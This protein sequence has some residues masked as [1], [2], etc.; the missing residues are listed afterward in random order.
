M[1]IA[2][3]NEIVISF[4]RNLDEERYIYIYTKNL[5]G[6]T[7]TSNLNKKALITS[8]IKYYMPLNVKRNKF[9]VFMF[10]FYFDEFYLVLWF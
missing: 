7:E 8:I 4:T 5:Q 3:V 9:F 1:H 2:I 6:V 10:F